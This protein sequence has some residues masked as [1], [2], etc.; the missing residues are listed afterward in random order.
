[1]DLDLH[2]NNFR[3]HPSGALYWRETKSLVLADLHL[4]KESVFQQSGMAIPSGATNATLRVLRTIVDAW[5]PD[6]VMV[7]G[8]LL[9]AKIG[10]TSALEQEMVAL[11]GDGICREWVLIPGNHDRGGMS[12]LRRC[13]WQIAE[14]VMEYQG[15]EMTHAPDLT[16][17]NSSLSI[18]GHLHPSVR[19]PLSP[20]E[21]TLLRCFWLRASHLVL[22]AFG[23]W[24]GTKP[25]TPGKGDRIFACVDEEV[26]ELAN[27]SSFSL[28]NPRS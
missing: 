19:I 11:L 27:E 13:G 9:H 24:T 21:K 10:L 22:P 16:R 5:K 20:R 26:I 6:R 8:D 18:A 1:M 23:G 14:E 28:L 15:V 17:A 12:A 2:G 4:G 3:F 7:L 25:I